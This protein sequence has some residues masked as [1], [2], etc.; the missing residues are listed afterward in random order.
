MDRTRPGFTITE[1]IVSM[2]ILGLLAALVLPAVQ[3]ARESARRMKCENNL[4][5]WG[6]AMAQNCETHGWYPTDTE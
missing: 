4:K 1:L 2:S 6:L 3:Q 5:Q